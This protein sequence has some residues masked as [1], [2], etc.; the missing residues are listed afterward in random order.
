PADRYQTMS[1]VVDALRGMVP[2]ERVGAGSNA[3]ASD[4]SLR[5]L[6][7]AISSSAGASEMPSGMASAASRPRD[8]ASVVTTAAPTSQSVGTRLV[9]PTARGWL[10]AA[11]AGAA[12]VVVA[13]LWFMSGGTRTSSEVATPRLGEAK[14]SHGSSSAAAGKKDAH[15]ADQE[16][17]ST[18]RS[19]DDL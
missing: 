6:F 14:E 4:H 13:L 16:R 10:I 3:N 1:D 8:G 5:E 9:R 17:K 19:G 12:I 2:G 15:N 7:A 18:G 11:G